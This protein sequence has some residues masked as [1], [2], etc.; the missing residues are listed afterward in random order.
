M[1]VSYQAV[2]SAN[3]AFGS[4][5]AAASAT[6]PNGISNII[7]L[8]VIH[9][10]SGDLV[11]TGV[12]TTSGTASG[13]WTKIL[14]S[15]PGNGRTVSIWRIVGVAA[16]QTFAAQP[17]FGS[18]PA[19]T[20]TIATVIFADVDQTTPIVTANNTTGGAVN[21]FN[22]ASSSGNMTFGAI[23]TNSNPNP[24]LSGTSRYTDNNICGGATNTGAASTTF[25]WT[26]GGRAVAGVDIAQVS[27]AASFTPLAGPRFSLAGPRG[28]AG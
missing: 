7:A 8:H 4:T 3:T 14:D 6:V 11:A 2:S 15:V 22:V 21:T 26:A 27:A 16:N 9:S 18:T 25:T 24:I 19:G 12:S 10:D 1:A 23:T 28:L 5:P 17:T 13:S 20:V